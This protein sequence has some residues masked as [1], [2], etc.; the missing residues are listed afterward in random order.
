MRCLNRLPC[1][2]SHVVVS[3]L[4][5]FTTGCESIRAIIDY[6]TACG[7]GPNAE[8]AAARLTDEADLRRVIVNGQNEKARIAAMKKSPDEQLFKRFVCSAE[9]SPDM[10]LMAFQRLVELGAAD[11]L[12][13]EDS[14]FADVVLTGRVS[15]KIRSRYG[16]PTSTR[17]AV[18]SDDIP[19]LGF[20]VAYRLKV[21]AAEKDRSSRE[22]LTAV[23]LDDTA[24]IE[25][26]LAAIRK[27]EL[28]QDGFVKL[29]KRAGDNGNSM[30]AEYDQLIKAY[31]DAGNVRSTDVANAVCGKYGMGSVPLSVR[32]RLFSWLKDEEA[33]QQILSD[34]AWD[35][36][37]ALTKAP[38]LEDVKFAK[39]L[40][41][42]AK[43]ESLAKFVQRHKHNSQIEAFL[44]E[45]VNNIS[46][47]TL[48]EK[49]AES[50]SIGDVILAA[51]RRIKGPSGKFLQDKA[52]ARYE[53]DVRKCVDALLRVYAAD[54]QKAYS[55]VCFHN[56]KT[57]NAITDKEVL[58]GL[59]R[60]NQGDKG[61][62]ADEV[63]RHL[64]D[65]IYK[66]YA[67][68]ID[69][70]S[71]DRLDE[72][73]ALTQNHAKLLA[74]GGKAC[75]IGNYYVGMPLQ[76]FIALNKVQDVKA[77]ALDWKLDANGKRFVVDGMSF[78]SRN[79][80]KAT[81]LEKSQ[82]RFDLPRKLGIAAFEI[83][84]TDVKYN[85]N[86]FAEAMGSY[87]FNTVSGGDVYYQSENQAKGVAITVWEKSGRLVMYALDKD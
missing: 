29:L 69:G 55:I 45:A 58:T 81:G 32:E 44:V 66:V 6:E 10:R 7:N 13:T 86:Y 37:D 68:Q 42:H 27:V 1:R 43:Q 2:V 24:P 80:F 82:I 19:P 23:V 52:E 16:V 49:I 41:M 31:L 9:A 25:V 5:A 51:A 64:K 85:R 76:S 20:P 12:V 18:S 4:I 62:S 57:V 59:F 26:R 53:L 84:M 28:S 79:L 14:D 71:K 56:G 3:A 21:I 65:G 67:Q 39:Y 83:E 60:L 34:I 36:Q 70:L 54:P 38:E 35:I 11:R 40:F 22:S 87:D 74:K 15:D 77:K 63:A 30:R 75:V 33:I 73:V 61:S 78:D 47:D 46:D 17:G 50:S 48:L 8:E 72:I